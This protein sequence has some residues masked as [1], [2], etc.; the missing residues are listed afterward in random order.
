MAGIK[1]LKDQKVTG[2]KLHIHVAPGMY[3]DVQAL[4][5][6]TGI[7]TSERVRGILAKEIDQWKKSKQA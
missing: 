6:A 2:K 7:S 5:V 3:T 4:A 1:K